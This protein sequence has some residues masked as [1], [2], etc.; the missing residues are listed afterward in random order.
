[1]KY[2]DDMLDFV[3]NYYEVTEENQARLLQMMIAEDIRRYSG[4]KIDENYISV[5]CVLGNI[6][7]DDPKRVGRWLSRNSLSDKALKKVITQVPTLIV[8]E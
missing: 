8:V 2:G 1:M 7:N 5:G 6:V 4:D 3:K